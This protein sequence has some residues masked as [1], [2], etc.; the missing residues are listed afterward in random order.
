MI[1]YSRLHSNGVPSY[2]FAADAVS[3]REDI[4]GY[5]VINSESNGLCECVPDRTEDIM[6]MMLLMLMIK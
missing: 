6:M 2:I 3:S 1:G 5:C 4:C